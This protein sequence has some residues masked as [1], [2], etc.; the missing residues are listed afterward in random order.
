MNSSAASS[1]R[2]LRGALHRF[3]F[4]EQVPY[5]LALMRILLPWALMLNLLPRWLHCRELYSA[6]GAV[7]QLADN[8]G[9]PNFLP[10]LPGT[11]AVA[12]YTLLIFLLVAASAG[13][14]TRLSLLAATGL[15]GYFTLLD[16]LSTITKYTVIATHLLL[17]LGLSECGA[18]WSV[19]RWLQARRRGPGAGPIRRAQPPR[20]AVWPQRLLQLFIGIVYFGAAVTKIH[21]PAFFSG[22]Q[23]VYWMMTHQS[24]HQLLGDY[25]SQFPIVLVTTAYITAVWEIVFLFCVWRPMARL[26]LLAI[27]IMFHLMTV[28]TLGLVIFPTIM[29]V[30]Y[31]AF[32][33]E[34]DYLWF[35]ALCRRMVGRAGWR[36][37]VSRGARRLFSRAFPPLKSPKPRWAPFAM[38]GLVA[39]FVAVGAVEVEYRMDPYQLRGPGGPLALRELADDE[40]QRLMGPEAPLQEADKF[41]ALDLGSIVAGEHLINRRREFWQGEP[42]IAQV[43][44]NPPHEDM[45]V[46]SVLV[47]GQGKLISRLGQVI[48]REE[49]RSNFVYL[50]GTCVEPGDYAVIVRSQGQQVGHRKFTLHPLK[51]AAA[52]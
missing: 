50:M 35:A 52:N 14:M 23:M 30:A 48:A 22:D 12:L 31:L 39:A 10:V 25:L 9:H 18:L 13:W 5:G 43:T 51:A 26:P 27:G 42:V 32:M 21:T 47:D 16:C 44:M 45:W 40:V 38:F 36:R 15:Y 28:F 17:L 2:P 33:T 11:A 37:R 41:F 6:D 1:G 49:N 34:A 46:E 20:S 24:S 19:D 8:F 7:A 29:F 3:F 4:D